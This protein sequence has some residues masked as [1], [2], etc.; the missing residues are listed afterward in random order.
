MWII[1]NEQEQAT[2]LTRGTCGC[3]WTQSCYFKEKTF[4]LQDVLL[5]HLANQC[6]CVILDILHCERKKRRERERV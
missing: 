6:A 2:E 4:L 3:E 1:I 5:C